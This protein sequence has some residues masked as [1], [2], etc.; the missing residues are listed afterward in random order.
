[1]WKLS[2][3]EEVQPDCLHPPVGL[4]LI[5]TWNKDEQKNRGPVLFVSV[6][7][8]MNLGQTRSQSKSS[9]LFCLTGE[10]GLSERVDD[11]ETPVLEKQFLSDVTSRRTSADCI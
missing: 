5:R 6:L 7:T 1:M 2:L 4:T 3:A 9:S 11:K 10:L 8:E